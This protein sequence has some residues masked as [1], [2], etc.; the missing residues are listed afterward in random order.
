[1]D[2]EVKNDGWQ[3]LQKPLSPSNK[4]MRLFL[5]TYSLGA[6]VVFL[7]VAGYRTFPGPTL[8]FSIPLV[9]IG[10]FIFL[11]MG[12]LLP[13]LHYG[14]M[15]MTERPPLVALLVEHQ[16][17]LLLLYYLLIFLIAHFGSSTDKPRT[18][19]LLYLLFVALVIINVAGCLSNPVPIPGLLK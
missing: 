19:R 18:F 9:L 11:P 14:S 3:D 13:F 7:M 2:T 17:L 16:P 6:I 10:A 5:A 12:V 8:W 4:R 15:P 1:M